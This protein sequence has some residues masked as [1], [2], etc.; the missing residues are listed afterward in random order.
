MRTIVLLFVISG[1]YD[2]A[3]RAWNSY[4]AARAAP[5][6]WN[7]YPANYI[8]R[9]VVNDRNK[10]L[11]QH[12]D[13][14]AFRPRWVASIE[15]A[16]LESLLQRIGKSGDDMVKVNV[17]NGT[18]TAIVNRWEPREIA[19][20]VD[21][22]GGALLNVSQFYYPGWTARLTGEPS[23]LTVQ[24]SKPD[25]LLS[26]AVPD[27]KHQISLQLIQTMSEIAG[28][29]ISTVSAIIT[30]LLIVWFYIPRRLLRKPA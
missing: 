21:T 24:P 16:E 22:S 19:L 23:N 6:A 28:Q 25:G 26:V 7:T 29:L 15:E 2:A 3:V 9:G 4:S 10:W 17:V 30:I 20:Q 5:F 18:G 27:G 13:H 1:V 12:R 14:N 11:E 8:D